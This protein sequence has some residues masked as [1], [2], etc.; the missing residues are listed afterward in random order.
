MKGAIQII[1]AF[2]IPVKIHWS[3]GLILL[4]I[5]YLVQANG[6]SWAALAWWTLGLVTLFTCVVLHEFGHALTARHFG[7]ATRDI[8]LLPIGGL[9]MLTKLPEKPIQ[10]FLVAIAG[11]MVNVA[12]AVLCTPYFFIVSAEKR[13]ELYNFF[14]SLLNPKGNI[15]A[16]N[17]TE[18]DLFMVGLLVLNL[19]VAAFNLLP[20]FPMDGGRIFRALLSMRMSRVK[21]TRIAT[22]VGQFFAVL[23]L[24]YSLYQMNLLA[25]LVAI[26]VFVTA[27]NEYRAIK[28]D[29]LMRSYTIGSLMRQQFTRLY[30]TDTLG[31]TIQRCSTGNE[32]HYLVFDE[33]HTLRGTLSENRLIEASKKMPPDTPLSQIL[34]PRYMPLLSSEPLKT[35][36][37]KM[38]A[39]GQ[40]IFP[41]FE[42]Q[43]LVGVVDEDGL[44]HFLKFK[45]K[46]AEG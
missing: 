37:M 43:S 1:K 16:Q 45:E 29:E 8:V 42:K 11:P 23:L 31:E 35:A 3:F 25:S 44:L 13:Q 12:I 9:A 27:S 14:W 28:Q 41:I 4:W 18:L 15:F 10:E 21:A 34:R 36:F 20:A 33:W 30:L 5:A 38:Q 32:R 46:M 26:F 22:Y 6:F 24:A 2:G 7:I 19:M 17:L 39:N 40:H